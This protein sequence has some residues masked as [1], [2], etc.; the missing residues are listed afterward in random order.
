MEI[1][2]FPDCMIVFISYMLNVYTC[3]R[4]LTVVRVLCTSSAQRI[5]PFAFRN[6]KLFGI[7]GRGHSTTSSQVNVVKRTH[8]KWICARISALVWESTTI[9]RQYK[10]NRSFDFFPP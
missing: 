3:N 6:T 1:R 8:Q 9:E 2:T 5:D 4:A 7:L 10:E